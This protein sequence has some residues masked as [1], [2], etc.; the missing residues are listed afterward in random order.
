MTT[1][2]ICRGFK[3]FCNPTEYA[4]IL[5]DVKVHLVLQPHGSEGWFGSR[6]IKFYYMTIDENCK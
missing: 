2:E 4:H 5:E 6:S 1:D 3:A